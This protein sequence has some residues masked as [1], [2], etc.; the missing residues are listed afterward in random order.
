MLFYNLLLSAGMQDKLDAIRNFSERTAENTE[1]NFWGDDVCLIAVI[2]LIISGLT[3]YTIWSEFR[4]TRIDKKCQRELFHDLIRHLYRNKLC[5]VAMRAKYNK[6]IGADGEGYPSEEHYKKLQ[7]L[8]DDIH[9]ER[10]NRDA[11]IYHSLHEL[12]LLLRNYNTEIEVAERHMTDQRIDRAT[13]QRDFDTLDFKAGYLTFAISRVLD[14]IEK[15]NDAIM[16]IQGIIEEAHRDN[17]KSFSREKCIWGDEYAAN[18]TE[19]RKNELD[20]DFYFSKIFTSETGTADRFKKILDTD[21]LIE[22]GKNTKG[23]EKIHI[24]KLTPVTSSKN[25]Q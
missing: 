25:A 21:L 20:E 9:L 13:K 17:M 22:C 10:Y 6:I 2:S 7:L 5:T 11:D 14:K 4:K 24:I 16:T 1:S 3:I 8:P 23:E 19:L 18:I 15:D 12:E